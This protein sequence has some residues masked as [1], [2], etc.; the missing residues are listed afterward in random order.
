MLSLVQLHGSSD[1]K[2]MNWWHQGSDYGHVVHIDSKCKIKYT[3]TAIEKWVKYNFVIDLF[4]VL[5]DIGKRMRKVG[6]GYRDDVPADARQL[7]NMYSCAGT[8]S[9]AFSMG[10][11][12]PHPR[13]GVITPTEK[14]YIEHLTKQHIDL[15][16]WMDNN[17]LGA[18]N[19]K[20]YNGYHV[21][22]LEQ[23]EP[24]DDNEAAASSIDAA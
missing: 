14:D 5:P 10:E 11:V 15:V 2:L 16:D 7:R 20:F 17:D 9:A 12:A 23:S 18:F 6:E 1:L 13:A 3:L 21:W 22:M 8:N 4:I 24:P 19:R